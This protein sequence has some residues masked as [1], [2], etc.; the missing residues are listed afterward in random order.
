MANT[1]RIK[2]RASGGSVG[3]PTS[4]ENAELAFN[5]SDDVLYYGKGT[6]GVGGTATSVEAIAGVGAFVSKN[7]VNQDIAGTKNFTGTIT[8]PTQLTSDSSTKVATTAFVK[9]LGYTVS[10]T[11]VAGIFTKVAV[12]SDGYV[13]LGDVLSAIDIPTLTASKISDFDSQVRTN[14]LDQMAAPTGS[15]SMNSQKIT[16]LATPTSDNDA[17]NKIYVD[18]AIQGIDPKQSTKAATTASITLSGA[19]TIDG[20][21]VV[22]GDRV[23]V[24]NQSTASQNGIYVVASGAWTR[25]LDTNEWD[26]LVSAFTFVEQGTVNANS[27]WLSTVTAGGTIG[28]TAITW[29]QFSGAGQVDAGAGLTKSG[30]TLNVGAGTGIVVGADDVSVTTPLAAIANLTPAADRLIYYNGVTTASLT[31]LTSFARTLLDDANNTDART[32]LGLGT[33]ATQNS[34]NVSITGGTIDGITID[35]GTF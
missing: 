18:N 17:A 12:N 1:I 26:E 24:K 5:E 3:A 30:N 25:S 19:Q 14:R 29:V 8:A 33:I 27:G 21:S 35:G 11:I 34:N 23:L 16:G 28:T 31:T 4:L 13:T 22:A 20:V 2:R 9:G 15:V 7:N 6:G 10:P 32:T